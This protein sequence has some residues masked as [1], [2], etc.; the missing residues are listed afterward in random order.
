MKN[1]RCAMLV[2]FLLLSQ[3]LVLGCRTATPSQQPESG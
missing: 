1:L 2:V 3:M